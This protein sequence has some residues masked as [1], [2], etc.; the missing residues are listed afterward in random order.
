NSTQ[1]INIGQRPGFPGNFNFNGRIDEVRIYSRA[2]TQAEIQVDMNT[3]VGAAADPVPPT[4]P[5]NV[6]ATAITGNQVD[7]TWSPSTDNVGVT[8]YRL[9]RCIGATCGEF[10]HLASV[11]DTMYTDFNVTPN[12]TYRYEV[13]ATDAVGNQS[14]YSAPVVVTTLSTISGL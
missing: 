4:T 12:T 11:P 3:P 1:N 5:T 8:G 7:L 13:R 6:T 14:P 9:V 10:V 2:L